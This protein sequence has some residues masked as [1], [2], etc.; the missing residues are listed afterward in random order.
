M[1][2]LST[3]MTKWISPLLVSMLFVSAGALRAERSEIQILKIMDFE[4]IKVTFKK[5]TIRIKLI[6]AKIPAEN[7]I[8]TFCRYLEDCDSRLNDLLALGRKANR[9]LENKFDRGDL[10]TADDDGGKIDAAGRHLVYLFD[11]SGKLVNTNVIREGYAMPRLA[12]IKPEYKAEFEEA[13]AEAIEKQV[14]L[15]ELWENDKAVRQKAKTIAHAYGTR[16]KVSLMTYNVQNLFDN[17][18]D[19]RKDD[20]V[21]LP[22]S[23]KNSDE[24]KKAC[25]WTRGKDKQLCYTLDWSDNLV[26]TKLERLA[27]IIMREEDGHGPDV[28]ILQE[29]EN[30]AILRRLTKEFLGGAG[31]HII[32]FESKDRRG[33]DVA[34]LTRLRLH[35]IPSYHEIPFKKKF[36]SRGILEATLIMPNKDLLTVFAMH[37]PSA[38]APPIFRQKSIKFLTKLA[39]RLPKDRYVIAAGDTNIAASEEKDTEILAKLAEPY[40]KVSHKLGCKDCK[41]TYFYEKDDAWSFFDMFFFAPRL[42]ESTATWRVNTKSIRLANSQPL[43][44]SPRKTPQGYDAPEF[45][46]VSDHFPVYVEIEQAGR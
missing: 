38:Q 2:S 41:G 35:E 44:I 39:E 8:A 33:I 42:F 32:H 45:A 40:W 3:K 24:H 12:N 16:K 18:H 17:L 11:V 14:G 26:K 36:E 31:Y 15:W 23:E 46:G 34:I 13:Y 22:L 7:E 19:D 21:F 28:L 4:T 6:G 5:K 37:L 1:A 25:G 9:Y 43:Q 29:V 30:Y 27:Q 10:L 20:R